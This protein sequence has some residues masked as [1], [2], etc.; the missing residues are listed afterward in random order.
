MTAHTLLT[1]SDL[2]E[3]SAATGKLYEQLILHLPGP[4]EFA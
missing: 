4:A 2:Y 3:A 1:L